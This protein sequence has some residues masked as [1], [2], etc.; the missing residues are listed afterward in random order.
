[1]SQLAL[2]PVLLLLSAVANAE[3]SGKLG[4]P[5]AHVGG[6]ELSAEIIELRSKGASVRCSLSGEARIKRGDFVA[7]A[8]VIAAEIAKDKQVLLMRNCKIRIRGIT[9]VADQMSLEGRTL[10]LFSNAKLAYGEG[11]GATLVRGERIELDLDTQQL[12]LGDGTVQF[13]NSSG[14]TAIQRFSDKIAR[15]PRRLGVKGA[16]DSRPLGLGLG[17]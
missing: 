6:Y 10:K 12:R 5:T 1:M 8:D 16:L 11:E 17:L 3:D 15:D 4:P 2:V 7:H 14:L 13:G 9:G